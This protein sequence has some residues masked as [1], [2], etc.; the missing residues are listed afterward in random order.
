MTTVETLTDQLALEEQIA[1][2]KSTFEKELK[3]ALGL[4]KV[5]APAIVLRGTGI[6]DDLNGIERPVQFPVKAMAERSAEVV[7]SLAKW[8][9]LRLAEYDLP[10]GTGIV[11]D[12]RALRPD[13]DFSPIHSISVDQW[14]W[15]KVILPGQRRLDFLKT[16]VQK[17]YEALRSTEAKLA[18]L[19]PEL[20][21]VLPEEIRFIQSEDLWRQYPDLTPKE[22]EDKVAKEFGAVFIIGI[23]HDL[24]HGQPHDGRSPD[25]DDWSTSTSA[26]YHGL[27][28]DILLWNPVLEKAFEISS[29][30]IRVDQESL[31]RQLEISAQTHRKAYFFHQQLLQGALPQTMGGGIGQ[32]RMAMFLLRKKHIAEVQVSVWPDDMREEFAKQGVRFL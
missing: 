16:H 24:S 21:P 31:E 1:T 30:G 7:Q 29:M 11:T 23:G 26:G 17:I 27:N 8:K 19:Y 25:Y 15:E 14:D 4:H 10:V 32:S 2:A 3:S 22:R 6:N 12:M 18:E 9:R 28:G 5:M 20:S 13:E